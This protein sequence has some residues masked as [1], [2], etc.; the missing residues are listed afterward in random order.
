MNVHDGC[1]IGG[2]GIARTRRVGFN[3]HKEGRDSCARTTSSTILI[4]PH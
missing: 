3:G 2:R 1:K 4:N